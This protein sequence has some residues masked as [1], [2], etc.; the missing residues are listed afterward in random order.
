MVS[1]VIA[2]IGSLSIFGILLF[3]VLYFLPT[4]IAYKMKHPN[5]V[6]IALINI[7]LGWTFLGWIGA[8][9]WSVV[10]QQKLKASSEPSIASGSSSVDS[11]SSNQ[12]S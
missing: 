7:V 9:V 10:P 5:L 12:P 3:A 11:S 2:F 8:L 6:L 4:V 1:A